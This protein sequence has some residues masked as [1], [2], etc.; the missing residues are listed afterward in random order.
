MESQ[1]AL[2]L[3]CWSNHDIIPNEDEFYSFQHQLPPL[4]LSPYD[5]MHVQQDHYLDDHDGYNM[6]DSM[7]PNPMFS[8]I[9]VLPGLHDQKMFTMNELW[10]P[11]QEMYSTNELGFPN[12][13]LYEM[14]SLWFPNEELY[15]MNS[16]WFP[17]EELYSMNPLGF[18]YQTQP[19]VINVNDNNE[20]M[21]MVKFRCCEQK[22]EVEKKGDNGNGNH[23]GRSFNNESRMALSREV[24]AQ[25]FYMPITQAAKELN[26]G[27]TLLKKRCRELGIRRWPHRKLMSIQT[28]INNVQEGRTS[29]NGAEGKIQE[30]IGRLEEEKRK[31]EQI[32]DLQLKDN[33]KR[34]RQACFKANYKKRKTMGLAPSV[35]NSS[36]SNVTT[37][38]SSSC[39]SNH[40]GY[41]VME[42]GYG[43]DYD[44]QEEI[45]SILYTDCLPSSNNDLFQDYML[46]GVF[47]L[48]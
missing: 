16:L 25:Y 30:V 29:A 26:V 45:K 39:S 11:N 21:N 47:S 32:P 19:V 4:D 48:Y 33:T 40:A 38:F 15:E 9:D 43:G 31:L 13:E 23:S 7:L 17:N 34:L 3:E 2:E 1:T 24:I 27:L 41:E 42:D 6:M 8:S 20:E 44:E 46:S 18:S 35:T 10:F 12:E 5:L 28:L 36:T 22:K 14:N 37:Q